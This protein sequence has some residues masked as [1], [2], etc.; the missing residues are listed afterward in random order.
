MALVSHCWHG[1]ARRHG[2]WYHDR[3]QWSPKQDETPASNRAVLGC[4]LRQTHA[5][6]QHPRVALATA[7]AAWPRL[8][9]ESHLHLGFGEGI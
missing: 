3:L 4:L 7:G 1:S 5:G 8:R 6:G 9:A 2:S